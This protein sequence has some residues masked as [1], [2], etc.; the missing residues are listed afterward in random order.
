MISEL[1][2]K[3]AELQGEVDLSNEEFEEKLI[4]KLKSEVS[5]SQT[6]Q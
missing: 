4:A 1:E 5:G 3:L 2:A 6:T